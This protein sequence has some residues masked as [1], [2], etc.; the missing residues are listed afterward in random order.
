MRQLQ[1]VYILMM[2]SIGGAKDHNCSLT[3]G[4]ALTYAVEDHTPDVLSNV[5]PLH[6]NDILIRRENKKTKSWLNSGRAT[7]GLVIVILWKNKVAI[8]G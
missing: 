4:E 6:D 8:G 5:I 3:K 2:I 7:C 1:N